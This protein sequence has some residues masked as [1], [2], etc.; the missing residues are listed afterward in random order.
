MIE[1]IMLLTFINGFMFG[2][3]MALLYFISQKQNKK[4]K[5]ALYNSL[6]LTCKEKNYQL[7][8]L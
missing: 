2:L 1:E 7:L 5:R 4:R 6:C 8:L 3:L